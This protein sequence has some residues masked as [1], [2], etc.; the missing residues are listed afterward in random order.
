[1][2]AISH[3]GDKST[4]NRLFRFRHAGKI[5]TKPCIRFVAETGLLTLAEGMSVPA[6]R[7][8]IAHSSVNPYA[9]A[10]QRKRALMGWK[11]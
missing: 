7:S 9:G 2:Q 6:P 10:R 4:G 5:D 3:E 1:M 8:L 11:V